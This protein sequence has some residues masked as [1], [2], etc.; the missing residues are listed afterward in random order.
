MIEAHCDFKKTAKFDDLLE[1]HTMVPEV[2]EKGFKVVSKVY[3]KTK[4]KLKLIAEGYTIHLTADRK[5]KVCK[6]PKKF[7]DAFKN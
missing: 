5:R 6:T 4:N 7:V 1:I 2:Y 3:L